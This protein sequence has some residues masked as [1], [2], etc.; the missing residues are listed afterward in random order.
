MTRTLCLALFSLVF[1][2]PTLAQAQ[3]LRGAQLRKAV[4]AGVKQDFS[5]VYPGARLHYKVLAPAASY[6]GPMR[7]V[8]VS[9]AKIKA[10]DTHLYNVGT[11]Y[12]AF[13]PLK[14][15]PGRAPRTKVFG[16]AQ[17]NLRNGQ[18]SGDAVG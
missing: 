6:H 9:T 5:D 7:N 3:R 4:L 2:V 18:M 14:R 1:A 17:I 15:R 11:P 10:R 8:L 12:S 13:V 16:G